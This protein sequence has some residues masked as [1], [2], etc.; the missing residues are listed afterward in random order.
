MTMCS[1]CVFMNKTTHTKKSLNTPI[2]LFLFLI[3]KIIMELQP[4]LKKPVMLLTNDGR[5]F[6]GILHGFDSSTNITLTTAHERMYS[7]D[8]GV[9]VKQLG[10]QIIRGDMLYMTISSSSFIS[11]VQ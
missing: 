6:V 8:T 5:I 9:V 3:P 10:C 7:M 11:L 1:Y 2:P 4:L